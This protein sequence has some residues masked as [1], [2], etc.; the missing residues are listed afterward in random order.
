MWGPRTWAV[1]AALPI[2]A[3]SFGSSIYI[4]GELMDPCVLWGG[5]DTHRGTVART[6]TDPC[7]QHRGEGET[8]VHA[9]LMLAAVQGVI[10]A[11]S[12]L[13]IWGAV[14]SRRAALVAAGCVLLLEMVPTIFS[15]WPLALLS[16]L[17]FLMVGSQLPE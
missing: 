14:R 7:A 16:G 8:R 9:V 6:A 17:G 1:L 11:A 12:A 2:S 5:G 10:L 15:V 3:I 4:V 13:G